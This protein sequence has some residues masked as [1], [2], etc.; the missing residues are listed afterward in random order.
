MEIRPIGNS[1]QCNVNSL[2]RIPKPI[3]LPAVKSHTSNFTEDTNGPGKGMHNHHAELD[4]SHLVSPITTVIS[5]ASTNFDSEGSGPS[6]TRPISIAFGEEPTLAANGMA[7]GSINSTKQQRTN[8]PST[9]SEESSSIIFDPHRVQLKQKRYNGTQQRFLDW[10]NQHNRNVLEFV[11]AID[12]I[13]YLAYGRV[14]HNWSYATILQYKQAILQLYEQTQRDSI[15]TNPAFIEF[16]SA[17][18]SNAILSFDF[19]MINL[20]PAID[21]ML[22]WGENCDMTLLQITQKLCFLLG[23]TGFL[24]PS[25]IERIDDSKTLVVNDALRL[26]VLAPKEK[27]AGRPIE[28]VVNISAHSNIMLC[29]VTCY[30]QYKN[31]FASLAPVVRSH[32]RLPHLLYTALVRNITDHNKAIGSERISKHIT[33]ILCRATTTCTASTSSR[34]TIKARA[35]GSTRA[36]LAGAKLDDVL[37]HGSWA[38]SSIFDTYYR[39]NRASATNFTDLIL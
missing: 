26:V 3:S 14:H 9:L 28:K 12:I 27:R 34:K 1:H 36:I 37:T 38:S 16:F 25:D 21:V 8:E 17:L 4:G 11:N 22:S 29:L 24:R 10:G 32:D 35:V 23:I 20:Q 18:K 30:T 6:G 13:N 39:L 2:D 5:T 31:R 7:C 15:T 19:P 33:S